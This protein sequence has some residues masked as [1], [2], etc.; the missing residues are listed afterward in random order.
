MQRYY[1]PGSDFDMAVTG[2]GVTENSLSSL[3]AE[4]EDSL[5]SFFVDVIFYSGIPNP[6][7][8]EHIDRGGR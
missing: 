4:F 1:K 5:L 8:R 2:K 6:E 7:L 3:L